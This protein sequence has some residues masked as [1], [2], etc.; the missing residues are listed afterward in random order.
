MRSW[1]DGDGPE[2]GPVARERR[3]G[4]HHVPKRTW[5]W[6]SE[7]SGGL[8]V[9]PLC[10][11]V[12]VYV[13]VHQEGGRSRSLEAEP[14]LRVCVHARVHMCVHI[15]AYVCVRREWRSGSRTTPLY[16]CTC[17]AHVHVCVACA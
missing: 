9:T 5:D 6:G 17:V 2:V 16:V 14:H 10:V 15:C 7:E 3:G 13:C 4:G 12:H 11:C 8:E 1:A